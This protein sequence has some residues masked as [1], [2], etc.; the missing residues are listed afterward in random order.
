MNRPRRTTRRDKRHYFNRRIDEIIDSSALHHI[1]EMCLILELGTKAS[2]KKAGHRIHKAVNT[3]TR[4]SRALYVVQVRC[5][6]HV[7]H[8]LWVKVGEG[9]GI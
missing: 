9:Y 6:S 3:C 1:V 4:K 8:V 7:C 5:I 2:V